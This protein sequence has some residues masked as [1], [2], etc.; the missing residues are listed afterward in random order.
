[1]LIV[2]GRSDETI[3]S[4]V[5]LALTRTERRGGLLGRDSL[6]P[7]GA[8]VISPCWSIHTA[9]MRF[10]IDVLF[11]DRRGRTM[12]IV[13][14]LPPWRVAIAPRAHAVIELPAGSLKALDLR[15][16]DEVRLVPP[17][18]LHLNVLRRPE[19]NFWDRANAGISAEAP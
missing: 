9:F 7:S 13:H 10:A 2:N 3:A 8:L 14:D 16:G 19:F 11:V 4:E 12:R 1:M 18:A 15:I 17:A 6:A 5:E